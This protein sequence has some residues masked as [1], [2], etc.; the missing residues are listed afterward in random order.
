MAA[1]RSVLP[2]RLRWTLFFKERYSD[3]LTQWSWIEHPTF[4]VIR[5]HFTTELSPPRRKGFCSQ[6]APPFSVCAK[7]ARLFY[8]KTIAGSWPKFCRLPPQC[9]IN[10]GLVVSDSATLVNDSTRVTNFGD[11][12]STRVTL[13][14]MVTRL[15]SRFSQNESTRLESQS[16]AQ[17]SSQ[18]H[19]YKISEFLMHK[20]ASFAHKEMS[21]FCFSDD[22]DRR[23]F[24]VL[25][26]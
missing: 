19:F 8:F 16:M 15:E 23:K 17:D 1:L 13:R 7:A 6:H 10:K 14:K 21:I 12:D 9:L 20:P 18:S 4:Q 26:V 24:S 5:E 11:S 3:S 2:G 22:Q 25:P